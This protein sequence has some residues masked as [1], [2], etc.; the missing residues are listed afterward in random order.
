MSTQHACSYILKVNDTFAPVVICLTIFPQKRGAIV[1]SRKIF[2]AN[3]QLDIKTDNHS[4]HPNI[5]I[6]FLKKWQ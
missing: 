2:W 6:E 3:A 5:L 4:N 1:W